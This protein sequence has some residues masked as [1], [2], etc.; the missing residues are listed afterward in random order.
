MDRGPEFEA[1]DAYLEKHRLKKTRQREL[2][3]EAILGVEGHV[4]AEDLYSQLRAENSRIGYTTVYRTLKLLVDA[5]LAQERHFDDGI[6]RYETERS[7]H[8]HLVCTVCGKI[9]E[10][11]CAIIE[12]RQHVIAGEHGFRLQRHR[13]ELYGC[14]SDCKDESP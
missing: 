10:F 3:L 5:G 7:H 14:C 12:E 4:T 1:L 13:H 11:E 9:I 6:A 2:I 8:D